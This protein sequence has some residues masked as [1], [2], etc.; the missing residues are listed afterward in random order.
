MA[1]HV[2]LWAG[3][4]SLSAM[5]VYM[6]VSCMGTSAPRSEQERE[7]SWENFVKNT[8][9]LESTP[10][11]MLLQ[12]L[13]CHSASA[14]ALSVEETWC[15]QPAS[16]EGM[17]LEGM[18][19]TGAMA[20]WN[21]SNTSGSMLVGYRKQHMRTT[22]TSY[23]KNVGHHRSSVANVFGISEVSFVRKMR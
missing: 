2:R 19:V 21:T 8:C 11:Q 18:R 15:A 4:L 12:L 17:R 16:S 14:V 10:L 22:P 7:T 13:E 6:F 20:V 9:K 3:F 5:P 23:V 1:V